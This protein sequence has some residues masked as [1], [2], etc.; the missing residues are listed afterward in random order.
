MLIIIL[1]LCLVYT[2][3]LRI[4]VNTTILRI[5][6]NLRLMVSMNSKIVDRMIQVNMGG[7]CNICGM[8]V[9]VTGT[10]HMSL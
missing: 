1:I 6:V 7:C 8:L 2:T 3:I 9:R 10:I 5:Y 4:Y